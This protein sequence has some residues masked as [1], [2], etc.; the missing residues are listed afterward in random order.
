MKLL[1]ID[2]EAN[3]RTTA[4]AMLSAFC[5]EADIVEEAD[6]V[7]TGLLAINR[8]KPDIV[9]L[10]VEMDDGTGFDLM[11][12]ITDP[13]FQL[14]FVTAHNKYAIDAF[15][16]S[17]I[18]YLLKPVDPEA[19]QLCIK[20]AADRLQARDLGR[21]IEFLMKQVSGRPDADK[22][23]VLKDVDNVY[24]VKVTDILFCE[25]EGTYTKFY[26]SNG[27][28]ILVS[29]NLKEYETILEPL[30]FLR[31]HHSYLANPA[32]ITMYDKTDGGMLILE[33]GHSVPVS[34]RK[35]DTVLS[36]LEGRSQ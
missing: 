19:L 10:D 29:K 8:F 9:M 22:R 25:A 18:D 4:R 27:N 21:Q 36:I 15:K 34:Q 1:I 14:V 23:I 7:Q 31:T 3:Q 33:G 24:F 11:R 35:K 30:G 6:G 28:P 32:K 16:F 26:F 17:A 13:A 20:K 12:Q 2:N 5:P